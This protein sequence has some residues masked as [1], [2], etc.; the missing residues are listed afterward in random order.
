VNLT[1]ELKR[2]FGFATFRPNQE[3]IVRAVLD[4][5]DVF[6]ALPTGGGKSLC[7]QLPALMRDGL[8]V[9]VSPLI[10]LM[11]DQVDAA[12]ENGIPAAF[13]NSSL[14]AEMS[15]DTWRS[16]AT[17]KVKLL[18][19]SPERLS[20]PDFRR[21]L[22]Q[23]GLSF[24]AVDEA[25][26]IS[27]WGHEF[28]PDYRALKLLRQEFPRIPIAAFTATATRKVQEDVVRL[29]GLRDSYEV[30]ASFDRKEIF[31][32]VTLKEGD[33]DSQI[34]RFVSA[35]SLQPGIVYRGTRKAV[36]KT[37]AFLSAHGVSAAAYH[38]GLQDADRHSRQEAF[39]RDEVTVVIA[40][41]AFGM[42][43]DKSNV[44]WV[45][46][47]D[48]P[49]SVES[50]Y[51]E[52]GRAARDGDDADTLLLYGPQDIATIRWHIGNVD[53]PE[54]RA[55]AE[56]RLRQIL[57]YVES[58]A[59][60]RTL[61]L[62]HFDE[63]HPGDCG[64]CDV[65]AGELAR[66]DMST[67][68]QKVLSAAVRTGEC[69]GAHHLADVV[70]GI[71]TEKILERGHH[72]LPT[73]GAGRDRDRDWWLSLIRELDAGGYLVRGKSRTAGFGL[74][75]RGRLVLFGKERFLAARTKDHVSSRDAAAIEEEAPVDR[76]G[77]EAL[78][79]C[80]KGLRTR[81]ARKR[82]V[83]PYIIFSDK[84]LRAIARNR[85]TEPAALLRCP[86]VGDRKLEAYGAAFLK[87][88]RE[89]GETGE[90]PED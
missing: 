49:R 29:L 39:V 83:P 54:E 34:L 4:G 2:Y 13:L 28:R 8:T 55:R 58:S 79:Q 24:V 52:T 67:A 65:C 31:Y 18:Y 78:L 60:R 90:C 6:A 38:A 19:V 15:S 16:L 20:F 86:G 27:E 72:T 47:G 68:A 64:R 51:Q 59:C 30:R 33:G 22:S 7:Y 25:H 63:R 12:L 56:E 40:T 89:F 85:P 37:A 17:G 82:S 9:V 32:R 50:Y 61:L 69:F 11:K 73:F 77:Q 23:F 48:L 1:R 70:C 57:R 88:I 42:G 66:E 74:S 14:S 81:L 26:C 45:V 43:I 44:R 80:L 75:A 21:A 53:S 84:T 36:E 5:R 41:I 87:A 10:S 46:H 35:H 62:A 76:P 71:R 3:A